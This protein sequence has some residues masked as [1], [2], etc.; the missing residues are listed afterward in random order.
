MTTNYER[1]KN[2]TVEEMAELFATT[3]PKTC[4]MC[5]GAFDGCLRQV[6]CKQS[7]KIPK[8]LDEYINEYKEKTGIS[9]NRIHA[10]ALKEFLK[11]KLNNDAE[12]K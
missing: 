8:Y 7:I 9:K 10:D 1:I 2:M 4:G 5:T 12:T 11:G 3:K 6:S